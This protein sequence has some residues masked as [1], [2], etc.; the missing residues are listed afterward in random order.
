LH[1]LCVSSGGC[2]S[3]TSKDYLEKS[4]HRCENFVKAFSQGTHLKN[5]ISSWH[6][7][8]NFNVASVINRTIVSRLNE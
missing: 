7:L 2:L 4:E 8:L 3:G 1:G 6:H 5:A